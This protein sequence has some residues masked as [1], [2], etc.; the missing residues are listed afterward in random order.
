MGRRYRRKT[1]IEVIFLLFLFPLVLVGLLFYSLIKVVVMIVKKIEEYTRKKKRDQQVNRLQLGNEFVPEKENSL[2][3]NGTGLIY[4]SKDFFMTNCEK[5]Y[6][7][8]IKQIIGEQYTI[9]PQI[10]LASIINKT[11]KTTY[12]SELFRNIDFGIFTADF[13]LIVLIEINDRSHERPEKKK[14][15]K[16]VREICREAQIPLIEFW[17]KY[18]IDHSYIKKRLSEFLD[19]S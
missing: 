16:K 17:T 10:N 15:D 9:Q 12:R 7:A 5:K 1:N 2:H 19:I 3:K 11:K 6:F 8:V 18:G 14:R 13:Q 4:Q